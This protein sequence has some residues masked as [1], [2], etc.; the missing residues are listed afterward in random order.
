MKRIA[1]AIVTCLAAINGIAAPTLIPPRVEQLVHDRV[2]SGKNPTIVV[3]VV[4]GS[5]SDVYTFG[6][7]DNGATP[8]SATIYEVG[9]ITKT[10][11]A[12]LLA[13]AVGK[14]QLRWDQPLSTL[15]P[16]FSIPSKNDKAITL[17]DVAEQRSGLPRLPSNL[18]ITDLTD[19]YADY[20]AAKLKQFL[21]NYALP[22][23][24]GTS[25]EYSNLAVGLL[26]YA[27]G[28]HAGSDYP[29][30][31]RSIIFQPLGMKDS[32]VAMGKEDIANM[33][34]G[35]DAL[36]DAVPHW[37]FDSLAAA[38]G[39]RSTGADM[40]RY[41]KAN[42]GLLDSPLRAPM[43]LAQTARADTGLPYNRIGLI[44][45][46]RHKDGEPEVI[47]HNGGTGGLPASWGSRPTGS[48]AW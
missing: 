28:Q 16:G 40:L 24:P 26:G 8:T 4:D 30:L 23:E 20:T 12:T 3:A 42:M 45:L 13:D 34:T 2:A 35:H 27:L 37:H 9:S 47:W 46:T 7:L 17:V 21:A 5:Q 11:T 44:W 18:A 33:A 39:I 48:M 43:Q 1:I 19:P 38:G 14:Q 22:R 41:L 10:F 32:S 36:G 6:K 15:L 31:L 25:F 29:T